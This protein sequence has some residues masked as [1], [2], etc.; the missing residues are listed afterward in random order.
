MI[1]ENE[2]HEGSQRKQGIAEIFSRA[3]PI[4]DRVG[5][6]F[7][8][9]FGHRLVKLAH[10]P[11]RAHV[12]D[13]ATGK[14]AVLFPAIEAVGPLGHVIGID[15]SEAMVRE[16]AEEI[17]RLK[18]KNAEVCHMD[19]E[20]L[21]F[22]DKS[23]DCVLCAFAVFLFP[24]LDRALSEMRRVLRPQGRI[25]ITTWDSLLGDQWKWFDE[26]VKV[27]L[28][29]ESEV[30]P[31]SDSQS[32]VLD[33][34]EG[35]KEVIKT[36]G[37]TD[38]RVVSETSEFVYASEE[39]W[40]SSLWSHGMRATLEKIEK[41]TGINGLE[42]FKAAVL[43]RMRTVRQADGIHQFFPALFTLATKPPA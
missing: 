29:L 32:P 22:P 37:F 41:A 25:A 23:F 33:K 13:V 3:A 16:T 14:G 9:H 24:E 1:N 28:P 5:P 35:L 7:F 38:I 17:S 26:L 30:K 40:W 8:S 11:S 21:E 43:Q 10:I 4:Y 42:R 15:L 34:V 27:H 19:A 36:A 18:L 6:Q 2:P 39:V 12:L 20:H 31:T